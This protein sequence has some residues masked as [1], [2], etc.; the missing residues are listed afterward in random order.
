MYFV[1]LGS[2]WNYY[3]GELG[4]GGG[5]GVGEIRNLPRMKG[6]YHEKLHVG[7]E[8]NERRDCAHFEHNTV[9]IIETSNFSAPV[10]V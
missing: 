3:K 4:G 5:G 10:S 7:M 8:W 9:K 1:V 6:S 2:K